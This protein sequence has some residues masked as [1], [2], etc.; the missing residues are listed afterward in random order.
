MNGQTE[1]YTQ[2][3]DWLVNAT[4]R[5]PE[6]LLLMAAGVALMLRSGGKS[7]TYSTYARP[8]DVYGR[9]GDVYG[10]GAGWNDEFATNAREGVNRTVEDATRYAGGVRDDI[11]EAAGSYASAARGYAESARGY[12]EDARRRVGEYTG[13]VRENLASAG[14]QVARTAQ[15]AARTTADTLREQPLLIA[16]LGL[17]TGAALAALFPTT[18][19]ERRTLGPAGEALVGAAG[20]AGRDLVDRAA[21][22]GEEMKRAASERGLSPQGIADLAHEAA[23]TFARGGQ[24]SGQTQ[25]P[26]TSGTQGG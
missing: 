23:E 1:F 13:A 26:Q 5:K 24:P 19:V 8:G 22:T 11:R 17:A 21:R 2:A 16:A 20:A 10:G 14:G 12:A 15:S 6:A 25:G 9:T 4:R 3:A 7:S 18:E